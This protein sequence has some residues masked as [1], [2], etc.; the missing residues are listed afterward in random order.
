MDTDTTFYVVPYATARGARGRL[1]VLATSPANALERAAQIHTAAKYPVTPPAT[2]AGPG[3]VSESP[4]RSMKLLS[5]RERDGFTYGEPVQVGTSVET[6]DALG[7]EARDRR[8]HE[9]AAAAST[10]AARAWALP[11]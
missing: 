5:K 9:M 6:R 8:R 2:W 11:V 1:R 7:I 10:R 3:C 4:G